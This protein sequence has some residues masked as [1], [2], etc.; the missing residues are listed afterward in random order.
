[1]LIDD[2]RGSGDGALMES[3]HEDCGPKRTHQWTTAWPTEPGRYWFY[4]DMYG[5][6]SQFDY[7]MVLGR[8]IANGVLFVTEGIIMSRGA[9]ADG[10]WALFVPGDLPAIVNIYRFDRTAGKR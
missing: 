7:H 1:M 8:R 9:S 5:D 10:I 3:C 6:L 2:H 4:G